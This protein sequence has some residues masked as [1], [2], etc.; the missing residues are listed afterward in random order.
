MSDPKLPRN[1]PNLNLGFTMA[2]GMLVFTFIGMYV[3][4]KRGDG[5]SWGTLTG[6]FVG[7]FYCGYE[8]WK[9]IKDNKDE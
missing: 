5:S 3:D 7:L 4:N 1:L 8:V 2:V 9:I 6:M